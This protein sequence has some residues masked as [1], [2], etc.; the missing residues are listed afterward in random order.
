MT[1]AEFIKYATDGE[2]IDLVGGELAIFM[3]DQIY[4]WAS[5]KKK[6]NAL[7]SEFL[8]MKVETKDAILAVGIDVSGY[9]YWMKKEKEHNYANINIDLK[10]NKITDPKELKDALFDLWADLSNME[11]INMNLYPYNQ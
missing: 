6:Y 1:I 11:T 4:W 10:S 3:Q 7:E 2:D 8:E 5:S 9:N